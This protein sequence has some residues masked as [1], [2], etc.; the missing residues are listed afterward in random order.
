MEPK[1]LT[2]VSNGVE[3]RPLAPPLKSPQIQRIKG[4]RAEKQA[5][6]LN[7]F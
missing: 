6:L 2:E 3:A 4:F 7:E 1:G 5:H